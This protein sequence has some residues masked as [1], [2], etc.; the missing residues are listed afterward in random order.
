[1]QVISVAFPIFLIV[2][3]AVYFVVPGNYQWILI[4]CGSLFFY[5]YS[6]PAYL[7]YLAGFSLIT[8]LAALRLGSMEKLRR[9][10]PEK[11]GGKKT[12][13]M[14]KRLLILAAM[15]PT[16][17][18][19]IFLKYGSLFFS[20]FSS[21]FTPISTARFPINVIVPLG[22]SFYTFDA[23]GYMLDVSKGKYPA[24]TN[25]FK[26]F[27]FISYFPHI[28][29]GPF[30]R[31][32]ALAKN[33]TKT[34][35]FS[36]DRMC[37][38][39]S[40]ILWGY[41][42][43]MVIADKLAVSVNEIFRNYP[44]YYGIQ[45]IAVMIIY[46]IQLYAD[47][48]GYMDIVCGV[49][50]ILD[51]PLAENFRQPFFSRSIDEF[52]RRWHI[53]LGLW[54]RDHV[55]FPVSRSEKA[56][57]IRNK[58]GPFWGK[59]CVSFIAMF[60]VW[61]GSGLWHGAN[62]TFLIW[63]WLNMAVMFC[64]Q[65]LDPL[66]RNIRYKLRITPENKLWNLFRILRTFLLVCFLFFFTRVDSF[67]NAGRMLRQIFHGFNRKLLL[68]PMAFF[69]KMRVQDVLI[70]LTG[71]IMMTVTDLLSE[72]GKWEHTKEKTPFVLRN[73]V[74]V[75]IIF[76]MILFAGTGGDITANFIYANF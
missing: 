32:D 4:L 38:G 51:I 35:N 39:L 54:F 29:Q 7:I 74:Y 30:S 47:F 22:M 21:L 43:K 6:G 57:Q 1:M 27:A 67:A 56:R 13:D 41:F 73:L 71:V 72:N 5:A 70:V 49:S 2:F 11:A 58:L 75:F 65:I 76:A 62:W 45:I 18:V 53:T 60:F 37:A 48:S 17:G 36:Y 42:K 28:I 55:F 63:G 64:S 59:H 23:I 19:W 16:L 24:E 31:F 25:F 46:G 15:I 34:H 68:S 66:Y 40:R 26:Y 61:S 50:T 33:I 14:R 10:D 69:P 8:W 9:S 52:W 12:L 3:L 20:T 44:D